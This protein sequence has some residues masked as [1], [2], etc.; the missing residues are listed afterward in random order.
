MVG[1]YC[2]R[3]GIDVSGQ[4]LQS[5]VLAYWLDRVAFELRFF[6]D[7]AQRPVWMHNNVE[8]VLETLARRAQ[9]PSV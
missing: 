9:Q 7:R 8:F 1:S 4:L 6:P 3:L 5:V 2:R